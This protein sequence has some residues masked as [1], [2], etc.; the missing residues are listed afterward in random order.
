LISDLQGQETVLK[1]CIEQLESVNM[2]RIT[3]INKLRKALGEQVLSTFYIFFQMFYLDG[4][5]LQS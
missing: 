2:A 5:L 1:Q 4:I 3:L